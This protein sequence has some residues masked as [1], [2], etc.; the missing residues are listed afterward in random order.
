MSAPV[1]VVT[2]DLFFWSR[3]AEAARRAG[4]EVSRVSGEAA[5]EEAWRTGG[6]RAI[7]A[8]LGARSVDVYHWARR[9][10]SVPNPPVLVAF[11]HHTDRDATSRAIEAG[12][13]RF[14]PNS[15]LVREVGSLLR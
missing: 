11:G 12:Y 6:V 10:R 7:L 13:H 1:L 15:R 3:I 5:M 2:D 14:V 9:F 4:L 8:D